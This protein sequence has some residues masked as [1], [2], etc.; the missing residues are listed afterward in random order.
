[1]EPEEM[2]RLAKSGDAEAMFKLA[3][4]Y[5]DENEVAEA[6]EWAIKAAEAGNAS[7][8]RLAAH[9]V[10]MYSIAERRITGG[11]TS[12]KCIKDLQQARRWALCTCGS[13]YQ[14]LLRSIDEEISICSFYIFL[15]NKTP[16]SQEEMLEHFKAAY[17]RGANTPEFDEFY[18]LALYY[19]KDSSR[20]N[21]SLCFE[22]FERCIQENEQ[23]ISKPDV[24]NAFLGLLY[25]EGRGCPRDVDKAHEHLARAQKLGFDCSD[26]LSHFKKKLFGGYAY[27]A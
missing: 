18:G 14:I 3:I 11:E 2:M 4:H 10:V 22:L 6:G 17:E 5:M 20:A 7:A 12:G 13:Y 19:S 21:P 27:K 24:V 25:L 16:Q 8:Y 26:V 23:E 9:S 1:M 15:Q